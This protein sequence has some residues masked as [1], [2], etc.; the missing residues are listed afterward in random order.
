MNPIIEKFIR[1]IILYINQN[2][3]LNIEENDELIDKINNLIF[4]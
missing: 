3:K 1:L 4:D 2:I